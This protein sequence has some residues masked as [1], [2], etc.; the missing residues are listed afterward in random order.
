MESRVMKMTDELQKKSANYQRL[1]DQHFININLMKGAEERARAEAESRK[2]A[3][4]ELTKLKEKVK[5]VE[6]E[7]LASLGKAREEGIEEGKTEGKRLGHE[8]A[9]EEARTQFRMVYNTGFRRGWKSALTKTEQPETSE[10]FLRSNTPIP[11]PEEGLRNSKDE[12]EG[13]GEEEEEDDEEEEGRMP[14]SVTEGSQPAPTEG[15]VDA[16]GSSA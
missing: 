11:Y 6:S 2:K 15:A 3:E 16:P 12:A 9:V 8:S 4:A 10:L 13:E 7:C 5:K 1:E 14:D